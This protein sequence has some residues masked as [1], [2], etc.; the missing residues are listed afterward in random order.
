MEWQRRR[1]H[2]VEQFP[3]AVSI[4]PAAD[5]IPVEALALDRNDAMR[6]LGAPWP[7][8]RQ[9]PPQLHDDD[10][11]RRNSICGRC[12]YAR[13]DRRFG[14]CDCYVQRHVCHYVLRYERGN[15]RA[16]FQKP[17]FDEC[18]SGAVIAAAFTTDATALTPCPSPKG[19]G[20]KFAPHPLPLSRKRARGAMIVWTR[21]I[22]RSRRFWPWRPCL[23]NTADKVTGKAR[24]LGGLVVASN[25]SI[26]RTSRWH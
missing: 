7:V 20:E 18:G 4:A 9:R 25:V 11:P 23:P 12:G 2:F 13:R 5:V 1:P 22:R 21:L 26:H 16:R 8:Q 3:R 6:I 19:R 17:G 24:V 14:R 15:G 10:I